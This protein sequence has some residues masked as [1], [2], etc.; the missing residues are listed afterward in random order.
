M[1]V[2][3][4]E[5][6]LISVIIPVY[7]V[8]KYLEKC[9]D[10]VLSQ[11]YTNIEVILVN[12]GSSDG[13]GAI[14]DSYACKDERVRVIHLPEN[15]GVSYARN[16]GIDILK[17]EYTIFV[18]ADD[19][20]EPNFLEKLYVNLKE[21]Q[22]DISIC[23]VDLVGFPEYVY[24]RKD[25]FPCVVSGDQAVS[26]MLKMYP[27]GW[28]M[29]NKLFNSI[30]VKKCP[31]AEKIYFGEDLLFIYQVLK[32]TQLVNY[33]PEKLYHY[34]YHNESSSHKEFSEKHYTRIYVYKFLLNDIS[35]NSPELR[36]LISK[37]ILCI[38][39]GFAS[40]IVVRKAINGWEKY[41]YLKQFQKNIRCFINIKS[42]TLVK[43]KRMLIKIFVLY[44][45]S[46]IFWIMTTIYE[47][48][49]NCK[50]QF[51]HL[52]QNWHYFN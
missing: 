36:S 50:Y 8:E 32:N 51:L 52:T 21:N 24:L 41:R 19:Y 7:N 38:N 13:S 2:P 31:F 49:K 42:L 40:S 45:N 9:L 35:I 33:F 26:C 6:P 16:R 1:Q 22:A 44:I 29:C 17:G 15:K 5:A 39:V 30:L 47:K 25:D 11:T 10:T 14:I 18:D 28:E 48:L 27:F 12:D 46:Q 4:S 23:G 43:H 34:V 20:V 3:N 37:E